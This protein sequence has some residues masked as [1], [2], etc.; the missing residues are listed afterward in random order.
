MQGAEE[1]I[2]KRG[3]SGDFRAY[4]KR[5]NTKW[6]GCTKKCW[7]KAEATNDKELHRQ[8][9]LAKAFCESRR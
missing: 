8:A 2:E 5:H 7:E 3:T 4:C 1:D 6:N 9:G